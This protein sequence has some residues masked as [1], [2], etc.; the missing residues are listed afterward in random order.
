MIT[1]M[2]RIT[3]GFV[4]RRHKDRPESR[5]QLPTQQEFNHR[6]RQTDGDQRHQKFGENLENR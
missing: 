6:S 5:N 2:A 1:S 3:A 4:A